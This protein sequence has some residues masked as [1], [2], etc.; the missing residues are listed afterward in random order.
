M[1]ALADSIA[2]L[3]AFE[4]PRRWVTMELHRFGSEAYKIS[5]LLL[6]N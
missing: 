4:P 1:L 6:G 3:I 2:N 5:V